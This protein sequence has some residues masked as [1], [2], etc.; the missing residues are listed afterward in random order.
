MGVSVIRQWAYIVMMAVIAGGAGAV[1]AAKKVEQAG[2]GAAVEAVSPA[3]PGLTPAEFE[4][5]RQVY[6]DRCAG[7]HG[8][9]RKGA[10]GKPLTPDITLEKVFINYGSPAGMP[11][12]GSSGGLSRKDVDIMARFLRKIAVVDSNTGKF[13]VYNTQHDVY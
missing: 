3:P 8:V 2:R 9:L 12:W 11:A 1:Q 13:N 4:R 5:A 6:F 10:T 7:C